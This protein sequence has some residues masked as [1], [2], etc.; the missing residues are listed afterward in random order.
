[1]N[2]MNHV[3]QI[4]ASCAPGY[5]GY[6]GYGQ[7]PTPQMAANGREWIFYLSEYFFF[8]AST[9]MLSPLSLVIPKTTILGCSGLQ[10]FPHTAEFVL[11]CQ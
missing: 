3:S 2:L 1:M 8:T 9:S 5:R 6:G 11:L 10:M 7:A 4:L